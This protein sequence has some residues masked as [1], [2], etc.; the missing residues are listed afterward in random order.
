MEAIFDEETGSSEELRDPAD[1][2]IAL[3]SSKESIEPGPLVPAP[4]P[5]LSKQNLP[6]SVPTVDR[7]DQKWWLLLPW[8]SS[9]L[10]AL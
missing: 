1:Y 2:V 4:V 10:T 6:S 5:A 8:S 9:P 3:R 7:A